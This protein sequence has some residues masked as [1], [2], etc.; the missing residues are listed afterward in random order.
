MY[1][2]KNAIKNLFRNKSRNIL[3]GILLFFMLTVICVSV[4]I[5]SAS[6][7]M[8]DVYKEQFNV[9]ATF[10]V[11]YHSLIATAQNSILDVPE[12]TT[13]DFNRFADSKH[14]K[15]YVTYG[16]NAMY[17]PD[18][19][20]VGQDSMASSVGGMQILDD[21]R[22]GCYE[23]NLSIYGY[24]DITQLT[25]FLDGRR[26]IIDGKVFSDLNECIISEE[27]ADLNNLKVN[28]TIKVL[29]VDKSKSQTLTLRVSG[30]YSDIKAS[31]EQFVFSATQLPANDVMMSFE[32][33][34]QLSSDEYA[35]EGSFVLA[36][37]DALDG[38]TKE[39]KS[40]GLT[41]AYYISSNGDEYKKIVAPADGLSQIVKVF[42]VVVFI[43]GGGI[44]L[45]LSFITIRER[46]YEI[47]IL[48]AR[49]M[50][51]GK[52][53]LQFL[54]ESFVLITICLILALSTGALIAQPVSDELLKNEIAKI[55]RQE[56]N[57]SEKLDNIFSMDLDQSVEFGNS[58]DNMKTISNI[59]VGF[60]ADNMLLIILLSLAL[61]ILTSLIGVIY[62]SKREPMKIL[63]ERN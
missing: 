63:M 50:A 4:V 51:K 3:M 41:E 23:A 14:V 21:D 20:A 19:T 17:S 10:K 15:D 46:K 5:E 33:I 36:D 34:A 57:N 58:T 2:L 38:F 52:I 49:G 28:D 26:E 18:I 40:K 59:K 29:T 62:V 16:E 9:T 7:K 47:G 27:L 48:R 30:I 31:E 6:Q 43:L 42:M 8:S 1:I 60:T 24:S 13:E 53:A 35:V 12:L 32:T 55:E 56:K 37:A 44:L 25:D 22:E 54:A 45:L 39:L 61:C 11:D